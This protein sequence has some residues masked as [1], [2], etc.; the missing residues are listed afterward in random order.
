MEAN[1]REVIKNFLT[2]ENLSVKER[3]E[4]FELAWDIWKSIDKIMSDLEDKLIVGLYEKIK[5]SREF[6]DY[7]VIYK[8]SEQ[9][10]SV[11][12]PEWT[13]ESGHSLLFYALGIEGDSKVARHLAIGIKKHDEET[14]FVGNLE[15]N[16]LP[17]E[18]K[19]HLDSVFTI[20]NEYGTYHFEDFFHNLWVTWI[21]KSELLFTSELFLDLGPE[22]A[23]EKIFYHFL[24]LKNETEKYISDFIKAYKERFLNFE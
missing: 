11:F 23:V 17:E 16:N 14:P 6:G 22:E 21:A 2:D 24:T 5:K 12:R 20:L 3:K 18:L 1:F 7:V 10:I 13:E 19:C 9:G 4:R 8:G 15:E